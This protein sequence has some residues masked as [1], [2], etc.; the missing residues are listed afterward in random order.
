MEIGK[1]GL[2]RTARVPAPT[3]KTADDPA[4]CKM[5]IPIKTGMVLARAAT[6]EPTANI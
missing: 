6:M 2:Q 3:V 1:E 4:A 5:R